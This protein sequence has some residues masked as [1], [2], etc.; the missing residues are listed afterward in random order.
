MIGKPQF[1]K[2][3]VPRNA[4]YTVITRVIGSEVTYLLPKNFSDIPGEW[5]G[6][7]KPQKGWI[8]NRIGQN[9]FIHKKATEDRNDQWEF[10]YDGDNIVFRNNTRPNWIRIHQKEYQEILNQ[11]KKHAVEWREEVDDDDSK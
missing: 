10:D 7:I 4:K 8:D 2:S 3:K 6:W 9:W 11:G 1:Y 5:G